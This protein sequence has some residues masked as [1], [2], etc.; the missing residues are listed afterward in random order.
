MGIFLP[1]ILGLTAVATL[2]LA[3]RRARRGTGA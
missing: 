3:L 1:I 2:A